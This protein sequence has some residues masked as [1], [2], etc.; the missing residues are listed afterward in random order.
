VKIMRDK[1]APAIWPKFTRLKTKVDAS[2]IKVKW[3]KKLTGGHSTEN[4]ADWEIHIVDVT[5][6]PAT[7]FPS[8]T[9]D[10]HANVMVEKTVDG[11]RFVSFFSDEMTK[12]ISDA[13]QVA[14]SPTP[15]K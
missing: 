1:V 6:D 11:W 7:N 2:Q 8:N 13:Q 4:G 15:T 5:L 14:K 10:S 9:G 3:N 12:S